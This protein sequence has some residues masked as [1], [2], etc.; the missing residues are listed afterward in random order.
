MA[1]GYAVTITGLDRAPPPT[2]QAYAGHV[3]AACAVHCVRPR[4]EMTPILSRLRSAGAGGAHGCRRRAGAGTGETRIW[5][6]RHGTRRMLPR[7]SF[8]SAACRAT[9]LSE[10]SQDAA[11]GLRARPCHASFHA[12]MPG[13]PSRPHPRVRAVLSM[14]TACPPLTGAPTPSSS[15]LACFL[16]SARNTM[17]PESPFNQPSRPGS[18]SPSSQT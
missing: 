11:R 7:L 3:L 8:S 16:A 15:S 2:S 13:I 4:Q 18:P 12:C 14:A 1:K 5:G 6:A 9:R 17:R 10:Q